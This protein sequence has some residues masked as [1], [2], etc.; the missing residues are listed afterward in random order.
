MAPTIKR[1]L[2][3]RG[4]VACAYDELSVD[5]L[6]NQILKATL[7]HLAA[8]ADLDASLAHA[9]RKHVRALTEIRDIPLSSQAFRRVQLHGNNAA[10]R[11]LLHLCAIVHRHLLVDPSSGRVR[12]RDFRGDEREMGLLFEAFVRNFCHRRLRR[13]PFPTRSPGTGSRLIVRG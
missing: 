10:Y 8:A 11:F 6:Q 2:L 13:V 5:V 1:T 3:E 12:F 4:R 7:R 9:A